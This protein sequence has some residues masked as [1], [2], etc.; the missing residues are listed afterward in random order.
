[1]PASPAGRELAINWRS[2]ITY[3]PELTPTP[4]GEI[5][6]AIDQLLWGLNS[7]TLID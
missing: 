3:M 7:Q 2:D 1:M 6:F 5:D 4:I